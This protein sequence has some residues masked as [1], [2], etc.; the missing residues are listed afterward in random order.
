MTTETQRP[1]NAI[2]QR[3]MQVISQH[4]EPH[5]CQW[6][7]YA[8]AARDVVREVRADIEIQAIRHWADSFEEFLAETSEEGQWMTPEDLRNRAA[9]LQAE[10]DARRA[11]SRG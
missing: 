7:L 6:N 9:E 8:E 1:L 3:A 4:L 5:D 11:E 10:L 2:E